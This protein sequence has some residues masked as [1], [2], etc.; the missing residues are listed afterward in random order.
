MKV[1]DVMSM[2]IATCSMQDSL[3]SAAQKLWDHDCGCLPVVDDGDHPVAMITDRDICMA[4]LT[5]GRPLSDL[6]VANSMS[7][8]LVS[9]RA[10]ED[11]TAVGQRMGK[12]GVRRLPVLD[13]KGKLAG[14]LSL[15][16]LVRAVAEGPTPAVTSPAA[17]ATLRAMDGIC[18]HRSQVPAVETK[19]TAVALQKAT[20]PGKQAAV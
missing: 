5:T 8:Q 6:R 2:S 12:H 9:C 15:N 13:G 3:H 20:A 18:H 16:D 14:I 10:Q 1:Q 4:A 7:K 17:A 11:L 19:A